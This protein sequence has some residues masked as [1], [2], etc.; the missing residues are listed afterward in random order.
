M[1]SL[2]EL[3]ALSDPAPVSLSV[4][5]SATAA[6]RQTPVVQEKLP[7]RAPLAVGIAGQHGTVSRTETGLDPEQMGLSRRTT[8]LGYEEHRLSA[9]DHSSP[10]SDVDEPGDEDVQSDE[11]LPRHRQQDGDGRPQASR[12]SGFGLL[13][14]NTDEQ[15]RQEAESAARLWAADERQDRCAAA[16]AEQ[17]VRRTSYAP[18]LEPPFVRPSIFFMFEW[19]WFLVTNWT[20]LDF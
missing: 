14:Q 5:K 6:Y 2:D 4:G 18:A 11:L 17:K 7:F 8:Q 15:A 12:E 20:M 16:V 10:P 9:D 3:R 13:A 19:R 1:V